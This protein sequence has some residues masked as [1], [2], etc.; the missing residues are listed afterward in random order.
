MANTP[1]SRATCGHWYRGWRRRQR[2]ARVLHVGCGQGLALELFRDAGL[3]DV[4]ITIGT[5]D[6][7]A[8]AASGYEVLDIDQS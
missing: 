6:L 4:G 2:A 5:E 8:C 1:S 3:K 7:A